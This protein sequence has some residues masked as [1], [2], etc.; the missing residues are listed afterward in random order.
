MVWAAQSSRNKNN[1]PIMCVGR[2][3]GI[4]FPIK[5][6]FSGSND[7]DHFAINVMLAYNHFS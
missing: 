3:E 1:V 6:Y 2:G 5:V 4:Y 7:E